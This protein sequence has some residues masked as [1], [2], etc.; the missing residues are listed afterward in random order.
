MTYEVDGEAIPMVSYY[1][2]LGFI[3]DEHLD[4]KEMVEERAEAGR[5]LWELVFKGV[6]W[7]F[8]I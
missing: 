6:G 1:K 8:A 5:E 4:L 3:I 7:R 2:Y